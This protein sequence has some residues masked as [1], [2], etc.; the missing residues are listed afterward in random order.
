LDIHHPRKGVA[1]KVGLTGGRKNGV[2]LVL[3]LLESWQGR[4]GKVKRVEQRREGA[5]RVEDGT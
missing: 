3:F 4:P 1:C 5:E 2:E